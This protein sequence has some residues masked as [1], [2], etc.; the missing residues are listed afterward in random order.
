[1]DELAQ[2]TAEIQLLP[3][4]ASFRAAPSIATIARQA[5]IAYLAASPSGGVAFIVRAETAVTPVWC[6]EL[7]ASCV[8]ERA[9]RLLAA[10]SSPVSLMRAVD[11]T[12]QWLWDAVMGRLLAEA[13]DLRTLTLVPCGVL[14]LLPLHAA[15]TPDATRPTGRRYALDEMVLTY[16]LNARATAAAR[17]LAEHVPAKGTL[18]VDDPRPGEAGPLPYS[19]LECAAALQ[20]AQ[21]PIWLRHEQATKPAV[22][23]ALQ[24]CSLVHLS[25]HGK[26]DLSEPLDSALLLSG[27]RL[28]LRDLTDLNGIRLA[29]L[30]ACE[31][32]RI[33]G[34]LPDEMIGFPAAFLV[35]GVPSVVGSLWS[36]PSAATAELIARFYENSRQAGLGFGEALR[37]AQ[38]AVRDT[39]TAEKRSFFEKHYPGQPVP[40][41]HP[42]A[43]SRPYEQPYHWAAF[44][45]Y[46]A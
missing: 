46:G 11:E 16:T 23:E 31:T 28:T 4:H 29:V 19:G 21:G 25:C 45:Y 44:T 3:G 24:T 2:I 20:G 12:T 8:E 33:G 34:R 14:G 15:W 43:D 39:T 27:D 37:Q 26:A 22:M 40:V 42:A 17:I 7:R 35:S 10:S 32:A 6:E 9:D 1:M 41:L 18:A 30:S 5:P 38:Q 13:R 36:V